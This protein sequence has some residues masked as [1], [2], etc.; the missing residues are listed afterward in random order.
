MVLLP[1]ILNISLLCS[2]IY[3]KELYHLLVYFALLLQDGD[4]SEA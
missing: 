3:I 2:H 4:R 1:I